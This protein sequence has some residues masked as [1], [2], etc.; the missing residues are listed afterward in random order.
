VAPDRTTVG[1]CM[2]AHPIT[3]GPEMAAESAAFLMVEH[4]LRHL[5]VMQGRQAIGMISARDL[6][7]L[8]AWPLLLEMAERA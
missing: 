4:E 8:G 1:A 6:L 2:T 5:P 7:T 3:V